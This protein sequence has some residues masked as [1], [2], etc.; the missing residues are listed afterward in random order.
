MGRT[1]RAGREGRAVS[2]VTP[3]DVGLV[4]AIEEHT[5]AKM[6]ELELDDSRVAEILVQVNTARREAD[7]QLGEQDWGL[8]RETNK[9]K[10]VI[11]QGKDPEEEEK[12]RRKVKKKK[13][14]AQ[15]KA[16]TLAVK[17]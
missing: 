17:S 6:T 1:A 12:R 9:R 5:G 14:K 3:Q 4:R 16:K 13:F 8:A 2:L 15:K 11:L 7:L 10:K